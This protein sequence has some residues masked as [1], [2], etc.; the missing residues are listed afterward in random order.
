MA[1]PAAADAASAPYSRPHGSADS[2][3]PSRT[4]RHPSG[5]AS[6]APSQR[7]IARGMSMGGS[8]G[9]HLRNPDT[10]CASINSAA[11]ASSMAST[12]RAVPLA[13]ANN[14]AVPPTKAPKPA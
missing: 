4:P 3:R 2:N 5:A 1:L 8:R 7:P 14:P 11:A 6:N 12:G 9:S 10:P 13:R